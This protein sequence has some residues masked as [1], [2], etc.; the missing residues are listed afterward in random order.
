MID[1]IL[2]NVMIQL[3]AIEANVYSFAVTFVITF[4]IW[5][6]IRS[7][8]YIILYRAIHSDTCYFRQSKASNIR[9]FVCV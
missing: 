9:L 1:D 5:S 4:T 8:I 3:V 7:H 2:L 6:T